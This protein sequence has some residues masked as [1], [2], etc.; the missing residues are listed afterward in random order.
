MSSLQQTFGDL[1]QRLSQWIIGQHALVR[2]PI[3]LPQ[4]A[5]CW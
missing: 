1:K 2:L 5:T 3:A 4:T